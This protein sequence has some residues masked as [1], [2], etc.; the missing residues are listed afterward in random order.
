MAF[1]AK[2]GAALADDNAFCG[3]CGQRTAGSSSV[4]VAQAAPSGAAASSAPGLTTNMAAALT[5][6]LGAITAVLFLVLEP[7][8]ND[9]FIRF[10]AM[11]SLFFSIA[12]LIFAIVWSIL[13]GILTSVA[14]FWIL[15]IDVPLTWLIW[16]GV[17]CF[18]LFLMFQAYS[19]REYKI[20]YIGAIA[21]KQV[22]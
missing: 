22:H 1:C 10:H 19:Q 13:W 3:S 9:R 7:Y 16:L 12:C 2:C 17:F 21:A 4:S 15:S 18:W 6:V 11:Q 8:K 14:G 5:Y 20:P